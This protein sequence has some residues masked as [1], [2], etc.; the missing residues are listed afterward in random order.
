MT[1]AERV[2][3]L[4]LMQRSLEKAWTVASLAE[5]VLMSRSGFVARFTQ[6][7]GQPP[8]K[9]LTTCRMRKVIPR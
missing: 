1:D 3:A 8:M 7:V 4:S 9:Y 5:R 2:V 6:L